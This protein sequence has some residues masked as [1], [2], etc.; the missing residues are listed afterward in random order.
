MKPDE[1]IGA[2]EKK[3]IHNHLKKNKRIDGRSLFEMRELKLESNIIKKAQGSCQAQLGD[4]IVIAGLKAEIGAPFPDT[5][6][7]GVIIVNI[8]FS[9][10]ASPVFESGPPGKEAV[11]VARVVDRGIRESKVVDLKKLCIIPGEAVY[12]LFIDIYILD[13]FGN[14]FDACSQAAMGAILSTKLPIY[15]VDPETNKP[16]K[17]DEL[18]PLPLDGL[19]T[20]LTFSKIEDIIILDNSMEEERVKTARFTIAVTDDLKICAMQKGES[21]AFTKE[22]IFKMI[23]I[24]MEKIPAIVEDIKTQIKGNANGED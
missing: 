13:H 22:Q 17:T 7:M 12:I 16:V 10:M 14:L 8:E 5:P 3:H 2:L 6:D 24:A 4:T 11:E 19:V 15:K 18:M 23:D 20:S 9:P 21:E 1:I